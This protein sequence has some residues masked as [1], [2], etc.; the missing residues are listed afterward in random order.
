M[1]CGKG[2]G[3]RLEPGRAATTRSDKDGVGKGFVD[4]GVFT[5]NLPAM[6]LGVTEENHV[7]LRAVSLNRRGR[8]GE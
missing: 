1:K 2:P 4:N 5:K 8:A 3:W 6:R 7:V